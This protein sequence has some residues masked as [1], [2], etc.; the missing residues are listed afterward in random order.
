MDVNGVGYKVFTG[1]ILDVGKAGE[2]F[3]HHH[4]KEDV[5]ALYGFASPE[6]MSFF[7]LL[8][9]VSGV[10]PKMAMAIL[11]TGSIEKVKKSIIAGDTTFLCSISGVGKKLAAKIIVE[12]KSKLAGN[13]NDLVPQE[14]GEDADLVAALEQ[15]GY[16]QS[17]ILNVIKDLP[18][19]IYGTQAKLTWSLQKMK[20]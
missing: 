12:L 17:E 13:N 4:I 10:G 6:E 14:E 7:E 3:I 8:L 15:L 9:T 2:F 11:N 5:N 16:K 18:E 19:D 20:K 1:A